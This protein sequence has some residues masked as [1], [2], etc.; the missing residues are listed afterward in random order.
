MI[1]APIE[2]TFKYK[3]SKIMLYASNQVELRTNAIPYNLID[4]SH[5]LKINTMALDQVRSK[6]I[7][8]KHSS[9]RIFGSL[10][11]S[12][13]LLLITQTETALI[14]DFHNAFQVVCLLLEGGVDRCKVFS[15]RLE[16]LHVRSVFDF[17]F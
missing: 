8:R 16:I 10:P 12:P 15:N 13:L 3:M 4:L 17:E 11:A 1:N 6:S 5:T 7:L 9:I 14:M 2:A